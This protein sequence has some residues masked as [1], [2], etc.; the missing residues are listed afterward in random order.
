VETQ[1]SNSV[2]RRFHRRGLVVMVFYVLALAVMSLTIDHLH[3]RGM[4][5]YLLALLPALPIVAAIIFIALYLSEQK[6]EFVRT[7]LIESL[8]WGVGATL[9]VTTVWGALEKFAHIRPMSLFLIYP[10][11]CVFAILA[12]VVVKRRYR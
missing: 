6:D 2:S 8:L 1:F 7:L 12:R 10:L 5:L 3:P 4:A 11:C 9:I